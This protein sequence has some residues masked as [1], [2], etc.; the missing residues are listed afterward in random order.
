MTSEIIEHIILF[1]LVAAEAE[2][3]LVFHVCLLKH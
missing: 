3:C 1:T 2:R